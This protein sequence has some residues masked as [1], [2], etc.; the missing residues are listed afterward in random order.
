MVLFKKYKKK[1]TNKSWVKKGEEART[2]VRRG[3]FE[4]KFMFTIFFRRCGPV[5]ITYLDRGKTVDS[6]TYI[7][8]CLQPILTYLNKQRKSTGAKNIKI[9]HDNARP[10]VHSTVNN[11]LQ[12][13]GMILVKHPPYSPDLAPCDFWLFDYIKDRLGDYNDVQSLSKAIT[14]IVN[15][16][17]KDE[18][19]KTFDK[20]VER[21]ECCIKAKG[22]YFELMLK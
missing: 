19:M 15:S 2:V 17:P 8:N 21:M 3:R 22:D 4:S 11:F 16:I 10:H 12:E 6:Q 13:H 5:L 7:E 18:W 14:K 9:H 1:E 20:W